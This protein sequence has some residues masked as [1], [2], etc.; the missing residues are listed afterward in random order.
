[1]AILNHLARKIWSRMDALILRV[2]YKPDT[3]YRYWAKKGI[4]FGGEHIRLESNYFGTEPYLIEIGD[5][6]AVAGGVSF[7]THDGGVYIFRDKY[8]DVQRFGK[9]VIRDHC[10]I[11][12]NAILLPGITI[13]PR[14]IVA[15][16]AVVARD[17]PPGT[18]V[19]GVP[20][21]VISSVETYQK[22]MMSVWSGFDIPREVA[23]KKRFLE[24]LFF[25]DGFSEADELARLGS[26]DPSPGC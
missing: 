19:G 12:Q 18:I 22:R 11:G 16:G 13:G 14:A 20:A 23:A 17:V 7:L 21:R 8:P 1:M 10:M 15:A 3:C 5:W 24:R 2:C 4:R 9:I 26:E 25:E 6:V